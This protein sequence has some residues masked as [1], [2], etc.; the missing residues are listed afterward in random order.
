MH[1]TNMMASTAAVVISLLQLCAY[2]TVV[3]AVDDHC[4]H[5]KNLMFDQKD[6]EK[7]LELNNEWHALIKQAHREDL[8]DEIFSNADIA[9]YVGKRIVPT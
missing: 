8:S 6:I 9:H 7:N 3:H 4:E 1:A 5:R 2:I